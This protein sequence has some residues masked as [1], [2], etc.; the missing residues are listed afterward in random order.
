MSWGLGFCGFGVSTASGRLL[1]LGA[2]GL[3]F[4]ASGHDL[5]IK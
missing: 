3:G 1:P 5:R 2:V 4:R